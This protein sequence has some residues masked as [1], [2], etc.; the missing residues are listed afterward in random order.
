MRVGQQLAGLGRK[1]LTIPPFIV[2]FVVWS[3]QNRAEY[4]GKL[5]FLSFLKNG[6]SCNKSDKYYING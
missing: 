3:R 5:I 4:G 2:L 6:I 1:F